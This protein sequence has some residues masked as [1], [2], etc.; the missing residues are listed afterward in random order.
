MNLTVLNSSGEEVGSVE[1]S[2]RVWDAP[3]NMPLLHQV[4]VSM[5]AALRQGTHDVKRRG[6]VNYSTRKIRQQKRSGRARLGSRKSPTL[7][8]GGV[9]HGP[10]PRDYRQRIPRKMRRQALRIA[11]SSKLRDN[12][13]K[14]VDEIALD[15]LRVKPL[16]ELAANLGT[17][18]T[19]TLV[20]GAADR[21]VH[22]SARNIPNLSV[23]PADELNPLCALKSGSLLIARDAVERIDELWGREDA[24]KP[25]KE[26][27]K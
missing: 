14:F 6:E 23:V 13:I 3:M 12:T 16:V 17:G 2:S 24:A 25:E 8:G 11:L 7:V 1:G 9:A 27:A 19:I 26:A 15:G 20:T 5:Q 4:V 21:M 18:R 22:R 10:H